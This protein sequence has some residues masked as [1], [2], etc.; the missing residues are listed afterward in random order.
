MNETL[1]R[2]RDDLSMEVHNIKAVEKAANSDNDIDLPPGVS[3][4]AARKRLWR[5]CK[6]A[7]DGYPG[8]T[9]QWVLCFRCF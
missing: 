6:K 7:T 9:P 4:E 8:E 5:A 2:E 1:T 3:S